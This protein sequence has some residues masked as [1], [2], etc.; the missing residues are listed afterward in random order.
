M[1]TRPPIWHGVSHTAILPF[2][3][4]LANFPVLLDGHATDDRLFDKLAFAA[5]FES[6]GEFVSPLS[7]G[8]HM[9]QVEHFVKMGVIVAREDEFGDRTVALADQGG[10]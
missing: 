5:A 9:P 10:K 6:T 4:Q 8:M 2:F 7:L 1:W 3:C